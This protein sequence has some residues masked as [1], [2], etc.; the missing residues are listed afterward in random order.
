VSRRVPRWPFVTVAIG[1]SLGYLTFGR[2]DLPEP[3]PNADVVR[4]VAEG[5]RTTSVYEAPGAPGKVDVAYARRLIGDRPIV[6]AVLDESPLPHTTMS[7]ERQELCGDIA[8]ALATNLV[9][10]FASD[11]R[12]EYGSSFCVGPE[13]ANS[14]HP[15]DADH[16]DFPLVAVAEQA[17]QYRATDEDMTP[18]I[19]EFVYAF[20][21]QA[22]QDY[23]DGVPTRAV[24]QPPP[25]APDTLQT[26]QIVLSVAGMVAGAV[27]VFLLFRLGAGTLRRRGRLAADARTRREAAGTE[28]GRLADAVLHPGTPADA[29]DARRQAELAR[30]Y[31]LVLG[32]FEQASTKSRLDGVEKE[33]RELAAEVAG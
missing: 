26:W 7:L 31:V 9:I 20:D 17:W 19:E 15:G 13:F 11:S 25:P 21:S 22:A 29:E 6:V 1:L 16:F 14:T 5:L 33:L 3:E 32:D 12:H 30:R 24:V 4:T 2:G 28:L 10:V 27:A 18:K 8:D 23:P